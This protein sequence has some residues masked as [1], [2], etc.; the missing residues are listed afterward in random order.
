M[1]KYFSTGADLQAAL[2][3]LPA[4]KTG[5]F[6]AFDPFFYGQTYMTSYAGDLSPIEHFVQVGA[7]RGYKPN[8][9]FDPSYYQASSA[10]LAGLDG[11]DLL[12]HFMMYGLDE[13][14]VPNAGLASFDGNAYLEANPDV[15]T[16]VEANLSQFG[17]SLTNGAVAHYVKFG[18]AEGR[19]PALP[20]PT[21]SQNFPLTASTDNVVGTSGDDS[22]EGY[23]SQN[24]FSG[25]VSNTL[26]SADRL[27]GG[28]GAD[29]LFAQIVPE[30]FGV[31]GA[32]Q[33]DIQPSI[34]RI[35]T[36]EFEARD[37]GLNDVAGSATDDNLVVVD[38]KNILGVNTIGSKFS[39]GDL[40]IENLTTLTDAGVAR[41]TD[42]ITVTMD[43]TDNFDSDND[44]SDLTVLFDEDYLLAGQ[45]S[46][47]QAFFFLLDEAAELAGNAN[48][49]DRIDVD[50]IRFSLDGGTTVIDLQD[51]AAQ[52]AGT[53][54]GFVAELQDELAALIA[55]GTLPAGTTLTLDP[56]ITDRTGLDNGSLSSP[57]PAIVLTIGDGTTVTPI[58]FSRVEELIGQYDV[59]GQ[60]NAESQ[61][62][63]E[64]VAVNIDLHKVGREGDGG[65]LV[66][67]GKELNL[68]GGT[69]GNGIAV[70]NVD[71]L[72]AANK[73][74][75]LGVLSSTN[76]DLEV[77]NI[78]THADYVAGSSHASLTIA[79]GFGVNADLKTVNAASFLGDLT[80]GTDIRV[81]DLDTLTA[82]GGGKV[83]FDGVLT[84]AEKDVFSYTTGAADDQVDLVVN[85]D[86]IDKI[87]TSL[88]ITTNAGNDTVSLSGNFFQNPALANSYS[89]LTQADL[90]N[91]NVTVGAG[92]DNVYV[93]G[94]IRAN[95]DAGTDSDFVVIDEFLTTNRGN[96]TFG[97]ATG[98]Q[99]FGERVLYEATL[100][101]TFAGFESTVAVPTDAAGNFVADQ[102]TINAAIEN[103]IAASPELSKL[104]TVAD[105]TGHQQIV[106]SSTVGGLND[107]R[108]E[109]DQPE[110]VAANPA[111]GQ[112]LINA[113][114]LPQLVQGIIDTTTLT[115]A[116]LA[117]AADVQA[118]MAGNNFVGAR[119][120]GNVGVNGAVGTDYL[121]YNAGGSV[122][123]VADV[124]YSVVNM[125]S[126]SSD[127][128]VLDSNLASAN[129]LEI[130][131]AFGKVSVVNFHDVSPNDAT[132]VAQVGA[133][134]LDF[135]SYLNNEVDPSATPTNN[136][137]SKEA[138][139][140][141]LNTNA[142][143]TG[144]PA[145]TGVA[146]A[147]SVNM[148]NFD[149]TVAN[150]ISFDAL[151]AADLVAVLNGAVG[152][153]VAG[154]LADADLDAVNN[155]VNLIG[156][157]QKHIVMV[158]NDQNQ[159]EYKVFYLT[160]TVDAVL[161]TEGEFD[162][163]SAQ[164]LG[165]LD[166]GN[167]INFNLV[168]STGWA[169][170]IEALLNQA[171]GI[172]V[173]VEQAVTGLTANA[174]SVQEGDAVV[175]TATV[176]GY[177]AGDTIAAT[178][179]GDAVRGAGADYTTSGSFVVAA[180]GVTARMQ[181]QTNDDTAPEAAETITVTV[182]GKV[183]S[184]E[185]AAN[186]AAPARTQV[187]LLPFATEDAAAGAFEYNITLG[188]SD[189][190][191]ANVNNFSADDAFDVADV[192]L[193]AASL[194]F[195]TTGANQINMAVGDMGDFT[196]SMTVNINVADAALVAQVEAAADSAA[197]IGILNAAWGTDWLV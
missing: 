120:D 179:S 104:L 107:L 126:G 34:T 57:I 105:G 58:G 66:I 33:I 88:T 167:S 85:G 27:D 59:Y 190:V 172:E 134:A 160:S 148:L 91:V 36:I 55:D 42:A 81:T 159:G 90:E 56:T 50:G 153:P 95:I 43:H 151:S 4:S 175:F 49:L 158:E 18:A 138:I 87:G 41:N 101:V 15:K 147:N 96:W 98:P 140:L 63:N 185:I 48:R 82:T 78:A 163:A 52:A 165:T 162:V 111:A 137:Q 71:V 68:N 108:V 180:D 173:P 80:L 54:A 5:S 141:T 35:E 26:S 145:S 3:A 181:V 79:E 100:T 194:L 189:I 170:E 164:L 177:A 130:T 21:P 29:K 2:E 182:G 8:A 51:A 169:T 119:F 70:F 40:L 191:A 154:G 168:G 24:A 131:Q 197:V 25:G 123:D 156:D 31:T 192:Y 146:L 115:S 75:N 10:D 157:L 176:E 93:D 84:G 144:S 19:A 122:N 11:A 7:A 171:D 135:T 114:T 22:F 109:I 166:F 69:E 14:R 61:T 149:E 73:L 23:L 188:A 30:F 17:G 142:Q 6:T 150:S 196:P 47:S 112:V 121:A 124:N 32:N 1:S 103:A 183:A 13:G 136:T 72:G 65:N 46:Q 38:A 152:A 127:L 67:G 184:V 133:H 83:V 76:G 45:T 102:L 125:G 92:A 53:H 20:T 161:G 117:T 143:L 12:Y 39:D 9:T 193:N 174:Q 106:V 113:G 16:Y 37:L 195:D 97:Q 86:A 28:A 116:N 99:V 89:Q 186:D 64:L 74:S 62:V 77:V 44:A 118:A 60:F 178:L 187:D 155:T 110:A 94:N 129:V 139:A 128:I 132:A